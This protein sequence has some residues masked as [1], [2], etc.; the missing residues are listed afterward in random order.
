MD[1]T[2][3]TVAALRERF[4]A[5]LDPPSDDICYATQNRQAAVKGSPPIPTWSWWSAR[6]TPRTP[7][8]WSRWRRIGA[9]AAY[10]VDDATRDRRA[11]A[12][13]CDAPVGVTSG[14]SVPEELVDGVLDRLADGGFGTVEEVEAVRGEHAFALPARAALPGA[15]E[16]EPRRDRGR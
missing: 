5:L 9:T 4:P 13:Q 2:T 16:G 1:E 11:L 10:L 6:G 15:R 7:S 8:G 12:G 14:A 3:E